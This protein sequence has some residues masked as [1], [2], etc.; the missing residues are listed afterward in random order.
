MPWTFSIVLCSQ[1]SGAISTRPPI[2]TTTR[3]PMTSRMEWPLE[4]CVMLPHDID[5]S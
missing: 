4:L 1:N 2:E 3:M 5:G